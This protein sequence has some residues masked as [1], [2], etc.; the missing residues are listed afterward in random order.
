MHQNL[1]LLVVEASNSG[2][3]DEALKQ[4]TVVIATVGM[5]VSK[6]SKLAFREAIS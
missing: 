6:L 1:D 2:S 3:I 4:T 5:Y